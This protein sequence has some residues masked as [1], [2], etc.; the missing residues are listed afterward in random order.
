[1]IFECKLILLKF[2]QIDQVKCKTRGLF[3]N[4]ITPKMKEGFR[5]VLQSVTRV[6]TGSSHVLGNTICFLIF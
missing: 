6:G 3:E 5:E 1:M 2:D 4:F